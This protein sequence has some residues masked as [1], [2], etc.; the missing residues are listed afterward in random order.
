M[1][2]GPEDGKKSGQQR[3][4]WRREAMAYGWWTLGFAAVV[5]GIV[6]TTERWDQQILEATG[7][8]CGDDASLEP[9]PNLAFEDLLQDW[10]S[11]ETSGE[12]VYDDGSSRDWNSAEEV[13]A[14]EA[15]AEDL[16]LEPALLDS[17]PEDF[18]LHHLT[19]LNS[20][21]LALDQ[22]GGFY[23]SVDQ[24]VQVDLHER[25]VER[26]FDEVD[27]FQLTQHSRILTE[28]SALALAVRDT[29]DADRLELRSFDLDDG[30]LI[31]CRDLVD[32]VDPESADW[33]DNQVRGV[34]T[35]VDPD[36]TLLQIYSESPDVEPALWIGMYSA[37][38]ADFTW[39]TEPDREPIRVDSRPAAAFTE[40]GAAVLSP[41]PP[42]EWSMENGDFYGVEDFQ[43]EYLRLRLDPET[44]REEIQYPDWPLEPAIAVD[45]DDG[46]QLW[47][48]PADVDSERVVAL[49]AVPELREDAP[50]EALMVRGDLIAEEQGEVRDCLTDQ[51][52]CP[53]SWSME[54]IDDA[55]QPIWSTALPVGASPGAV[56]LWGD[57]IVRQED[58]AWTEDYE[59]SPEEGTLTGYDLHTGEELWSTQDV[60][61]SHIGEAV[62]TDAGWLVFAHHT[63]SD[64][65]EET[66]AVID[67][68][69]GEVMDSGGD[70]E[71]ISAVASDEEFLILHVTNA[72][73]DELAVLRRPED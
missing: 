57:V 31:D 1:A 52:Y 58:E 63:D 9:M 10:D 44:W 17:Q 19:A 13:Q 11:A 62:E 32:D 51:G 27:L 67:P 47:E 69:S 56:A 71:S 38:E 49:P 53:I 41:H 2:E 46:T 4:G 55:G 37:E 39:E 50:G 72:R 21:T 26:A 20:N 42:A 60:R 15:V 29:V 73:S 5:V 48:Y 7:L 35:P 23:T 70:L 43:D 25:E 68:E 6:G 12:I 34:L 22:P 59:D 45:L 54:L 18:D 66:Y 61:N 16:N 64:Q 30:S 40:S 65:G 36:R 24:V 3:S 33:L 8:N 28:D 14:I